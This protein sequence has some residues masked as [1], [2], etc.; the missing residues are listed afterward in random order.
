MRQLGLCCI[1]LFLSATPFSFASAASTEQLWIAWSDGRSVDDAWDSGAAVRDRFPDA[2]VLADAAS[3]ERLVAVGFR[4]EGAVVLGPGASVTLLHAK[5]AGSSPALDATALAQSGVTLAWRQGR[6]AIVT[7][8]GAFPAEA[9]PA[10]WTAKALRAEPLRRPPAGG[11]TVS[12]TLATAFEP[13]IQEMV[14]SVDVNAY[15]QWIGN[16]AGANPVTIGGNPWTF[17]T[18]STPTPQC[19]LAEQYVYEQLQAM[20]FADVQY[21]P[22]VFSSTSARNVIATLPGVE[23]PQRIYIV[24]AH[25]DST[26]PSAA[27]L[28]PGA[29]DNASGI[30]TVLAIANILKSHTFR[31]TIRFIVFTGEEQGLHGSTH[32]AQAAAARGDSILGVVICDMVSWYNASYRIDVEGET[33]WLPL[34]RVMED[35]CATYTGLATNEV[36]SSWGSDHVPFQD[37]GYPAFLAIENEY[38]SYSCYHQTCDTTEKQKAA[39]GADVTRACLATVAHLAGPRGFGIAHTPLANTEDLNGPYEVLARVTQIEPLD[40]GSLLLHWSM[41]WEYV[42]VPLV[43]TGAP[44]MY[45]AYI[46]GPRQSQGFTYWLAAADS[47]SHT[48]THPASAPAAVHSFFAGPR[49]TLYNEDFEAG[50]PGWMHGGVG[51]DWQLDTPRGLAEDPASAHSGTRVYGTD[52]TGLGA[53]T[54]KYENNCESWLESPPIDCSTAAGV[55][56][57][58]WRW[59]AIERSNGQRWDWARVLVNGTAIWES[60]SQANLVDAM[61]QQMEFDIAALA[62]GNPAVR[63]RL[64]LHSDASVTFGGWNVDDVRLTG[65]STVVPTDVAGDALRRTVILHPAVPN[66]S[67]PS[68]TLRFDLQARGAVDLSIYDARGRLVRVL[69]RGPQNAGKHTV[70]W[71]GRGDNGEPRPSGVYFCRLVTPEGVHKTK[72]TLVR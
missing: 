30:A 72:V 5:A 9:I 63:I 34:M 15:M 43:P 22:Y 32:Y 41:G 6:N 2:L 48:A 16:L 61:W 42:T 8:A 39:F 35:A 54:G 19:D 38:S 29:N 57:E 64:S 12:K 33:A 3:A 21:D 52:L 66:P 26:S 37:A 67:N 58:L 28:A 7:T 23:T 36:L 1:V 27:T 56:L 18:R 44:E 62:D 31:S 69:V 49:A 50:A 13:V 70:V 10:G 24:G 51:D 17:T 59:L 14:D 68:S 53:G 65:I 55:R 4:V 60:P 20:G 47:A 40:P 25:L 45:H 71:D 11:A 46:P